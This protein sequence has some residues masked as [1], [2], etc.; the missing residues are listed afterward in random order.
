MEPKD[1]AIEEMMK[2]FVI[3]STL[4]LL[5]THEEVAPNSNV[6]NTFEVM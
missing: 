3:L 2:G 4:D 6:V 1:A 5:K